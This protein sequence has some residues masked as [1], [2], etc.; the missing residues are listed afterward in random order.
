MTMARPA[1]SI[2][3]VGLA[4]AALT[5]SVGSAVAN[6]VFPDSTEDQAFH[7]QVGYVAGAGCA[8]GFPN[9][10]FKPLDSVNRQQFAAWM[11]RCGGRVTHTVGGGTTLTTTETFADVGGSVF[12]RAGATGDIALGGFVHVTASVNAR[13]THPADANCPCFISVRIEDRTDAAIS[14]AVSGVVSPGTDPTFGDGA[15]TLP[16]TATF[17]IDPDE[18]KQFGIEAAFFDADVTGVTFNVQVNAIYVPFGPDG[19]NTLVFEGA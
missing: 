15:T 10:T 9:G 1:R 16:V 8:T 17:P 5:V 6:H 19:D 14:S 12:I 4:L 7:E 11:N 2:L 18:T 13:V 3:A